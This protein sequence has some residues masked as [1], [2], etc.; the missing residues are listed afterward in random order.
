MRFNKHPQEKGLLKVDLIFYC[1]STRY[2]IT[3]PCSPKLFNVLILHC[4]SALKSSPSKK[5]RVSLSVPKCAGPGAAWSASQLPSERDENIYDL[6][7]ARSFP[8][9]EDEGEQHLYTILQQRDLNQDNQTDSRNR[10]HPQMQILPEFTI[11]V[12]NRLIAVAMENKRLHEQNSTS[13]KEKLKS[14]K[15][16]GTSSLTHK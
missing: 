15:R 2:H 13:E 5:G 14:R 11:N 16:T 6:R 9:L 3:R 1:D 10:G 8:T 12:N 7:G 4:P